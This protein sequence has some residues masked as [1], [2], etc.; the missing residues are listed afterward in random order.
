MDQLVLDLV[1]CL[2]TLFRTSSKISEQFCFS[3]DSYKEDYL[4][5]M[6]RALKYVKECRKLGVS[7]NSQ[8]SKK[9]Y[10]DG[11]VVARGLSRVSCRLLKNCWMEK[12]S[13][14]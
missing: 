1:V 6:Q 13:I 2:L 4:D 14:R 3:A 5:C 11:R 7:D 9:A 10:R 8:I 12:L